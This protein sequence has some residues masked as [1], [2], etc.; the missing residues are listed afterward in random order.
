M[1]VQVIALVTINEDEPIAL[2]KYLET[3]APLLEEAGARIVQRFDIG[4]AVV[5]GV[6]AQTVIVVDY[7]DR[8]AVD[9]VFQ[10]DV[11]RDVRPYRDKAF[12]D[13]KV[14]VVTNQPDAVSEPE[15][16]TPIKST[17]T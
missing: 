14:S 13:Y 1:T 10:S 6:P 8:D 16:R 12:R 9:R 2:A 7:P 5:G 4:E 15:R 3:T 17:E 11:Y